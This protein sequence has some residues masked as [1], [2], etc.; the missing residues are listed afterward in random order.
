MKVA[1]MTQRFFVLKNPEPPEPSSVHFKGHPAYGRGT[2]EYRYG[3]ALWADDMEYDAHFEPIRENPRVLRLHHGLLRTVLPSPAAVGDFVWTVYN[4]CVVTDRVRQLLL[5]EGF[6]GFATE[7]V[8]V[9]KFKRRSKRVSNPPL[10]FELLVFGR[11]GPPDP[12]SGSVRLTE[13]DE[14]G[15]AT[16]SSYKNGLLVNE[17]TWDGSDFF[18][19][20]GWEQHVIIANRVKDFIV[21][22]QLSNCMLIP[23]ENLTWP[24]H[25]ETPEDWMVQKQ[26][27]GGGHQKDGR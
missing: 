1:E 11:G 3:L 26:V 22:E 15:F 9:E 8:I 12:G 27:D 6:T 23:V 20:E 4:E 21:K 7:P 5:E 14:R 17:E 19:L 24:A 10:L 16:Y 13:P 25:L 18:A 2:D